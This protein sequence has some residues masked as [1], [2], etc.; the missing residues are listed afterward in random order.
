M[1]GEGE[2]IPSGELPAP[3]TSA[4]PPP[5]NSISPAP[6]ARR[7][8]FGRSPVHGIWSRTSSAVYLGIGGAG[9]IGVF[10]LLGA[11]GYYSVP[12]ILQTLPQGF[13]P[14]QIS[15]EFTTYT[16]VL[17]LL[18]ALGLGLVRAH[19][20]RRDPGATS[21]GARARFA[22]LW[23]WPLYGFASGYVAAVRG[24][25]FLVQLQIV[26]LAIIFTSPRF[27]FLGWNAAYWAGFFA[28]LINTT[29]YQAEAIRGGVQSVEAGQIEGAKAVGL[30]RFQIFARITLPQSL[31][32]ITL[33]LT[34]E[35]I[36]N[37]KTATIL[38]YIGVFE[39]FDWSRTDIALTDARPIEA[40]VLLTI[41]Y[42]IINV[43][44]SR[45]ITYVEKVRR[46]PGLGSPI[47]EVG[48][49]KR[50]FAL[51]TGTDRRKRRD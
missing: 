18:G 2:P 21:K 24:T 36:S 20:P 15:L 25:P 44:L 13:G 27:A 45:V 9:A 46:I 8:G 50:L 22:F 23:R 40:F 35:W 38:S 42:L 26:Y 19:P 41:F 49:S 4:S 10:F 28:L 7:V 51:G 29:G 5:R 31:R 34:N 6:I 1:D 17:G 14:V 47:P 39:V 33:P 43:T 12:F 32:L 37:F 11:L 48:M 30:G 16:F 3:E